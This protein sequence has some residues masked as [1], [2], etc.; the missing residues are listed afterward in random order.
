MFVYLYF[1][2]GFPLLLV[3]CIFLNCSQSESEK[4]IKDLEEK[5]KKI[6][7]DLKVLDYHFGNI[8]FSYPLNIFRIE[9]RLDELEKKNKKEIKK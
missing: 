6:E 3:F 7:Q 8:R 9:R 5:N 1:I 2:L 4:K